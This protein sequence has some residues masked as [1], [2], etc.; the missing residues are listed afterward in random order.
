MKTAESVAVFNGKQIAG[1]GMAFKPTV[2]GQLGFG[3]NHDKP[4]DNQGFMDI[5]V[6]SPGVMRA[7]GTPIRTQGAC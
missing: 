1:F 6:M 3:P 5:G 7:T 4:G 2:A